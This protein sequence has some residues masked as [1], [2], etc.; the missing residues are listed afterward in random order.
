MKDFDYKEFKYQAITQCGPTF[1]SFGFDPVTILTILQL[2][3][4]MLGNCLTKVT[5]S[6]AAIRIKKG[7]IGTKIALTK[8]VSEALKKRGEKS[9]ASQREAVRDSVMEFLKGQSNETI[10]G[11][12]ENAKDHPN[13]GSLAL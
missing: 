5:P 6:E 12:C 3:A 11:M 10:I 4:P 2:V 1:R 7:D 9:N 8:A 13:L